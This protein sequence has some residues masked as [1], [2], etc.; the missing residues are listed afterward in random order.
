MKL[1]THLRSSSLEY[2]HNIARFWELEPESGEIGKTPEALA[3][4]LYPRLQIST[5]FRRIF[6]KLDG[7]QRDLIYFLAL[8]GGEIPLDEC[9]QRM[10]LDPEG[11]LD[12]RIAQLNQLGFVWTEKLRDI[13]YRTVCFLPRRPNSGQK[14]PKSNTAKPNSGFAYVCDLARHYATV[15]K[16]RNL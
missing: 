14:F 1:K 15:T 16:E 10:A 11:S 9:R 12:D 5:Q 13:P 2:L 6:E 3:S 4:Y 7:S 8:H